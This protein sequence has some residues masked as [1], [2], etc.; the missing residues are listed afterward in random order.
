M[1]AAAEGLGLDRVFIAGVSPIVL[2]DMTS[3]YNVGKS[4]DLE[5]DFN[6]L[7]G[8]TETEVG[9]ML[10]QLAAE[11]A[12]WS[13]D[14]VLATMRTLYNGYRFSPRTQTALYNPTLSLYFLKALLRHGS[15]PE[16]LLD[17]N[18]AMDRGKL[19][20]I[21]RLAHGEALLIEA[22]SGDDRVMIPQLARR[23]GIEECWW[24]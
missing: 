17:E 22:L 12:A 4:I 24:R 5:P 20:Y 18:L 3:G 13:P 9:T 15:A 8:F 11:G 2:S 6:D 19:T 23:L 21:A 1:K 16:P 14:E 10:G 7:C